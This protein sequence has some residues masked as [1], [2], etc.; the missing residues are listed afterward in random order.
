MNRCGT[1]GKYTARAAQ[2]KR[3]KKLTPGGGDVADKKAAVKTLYA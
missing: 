1:S 2:K 3:R